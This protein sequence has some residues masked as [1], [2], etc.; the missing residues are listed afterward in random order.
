M[1]ELLLNLMT[2]GYRVSFNPHFSRNTFQLRMKDEEGNSAE[3]ILDVR[4]S[5]KE[6]YNHLKELSTR[7]INCQL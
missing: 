6:L 4:L 2:L 1:E 7:I 3:A 5:D